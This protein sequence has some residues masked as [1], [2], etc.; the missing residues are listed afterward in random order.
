[1]TNA[2]KFAVVVQCRAR[3]KVAVGL[4][5]LADC[6]AEEE[7]Y[8]KMCFGAVGAL[9]PRLGDHKR[10]R[11][12]MF[13]LEHWNSL[14]VRQRRIAKQAAMENWND[15]E[16]LEV[17]NHL[18]EL[19][20]LEKHLLSEWVPIACPSSA[21]TGVIISVEFIQILFKPACDDHEVMKGFHQK[22]FRTREY[23]RYVQIIADEICQQTKCTFGS[24]TV[25]RRSIAHV[26]CETVVLRLQSFYSERRKTIKIET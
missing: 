22:L 5:G 14:T 1:L 19:A 3:L 6:L 8:Q 20:L 16:L 10:V 12:L 25:A 17:A 23:C 7:K 11:L 2:A 18:N 4:M 24:A 13:F 26:F 21:K 15:P 9:S